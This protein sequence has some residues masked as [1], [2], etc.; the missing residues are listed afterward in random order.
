M[1]KFVA[2]IEVDR[3][4]TQLDRVTRQ[5]REATARCE[6]AFDQGAAMVINALRAGAA[7]EDVER[8]VRWEH[9]NDAA[10]APTQLAIPTAPA[11]VQVPSMCQ[12]TDRICIPLEFE[13]SDEF[14]DPMI[15]IP[16]I[17]E[18]S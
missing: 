10:K 14:T 7:L 1:S 4:Y 6:R 12:D 3:R 16:L 8:K 5:L 17:P 18:K 15:S 9:V 13:D 2:A 11:P